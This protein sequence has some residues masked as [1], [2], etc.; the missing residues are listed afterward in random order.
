MTSKVEIISEALNLLGL[1]PISSTA[2]FPGNNPAW[3]AANKWYDRLLSS[4]LGDG[5][6]WR[7]AMVTRQLSVLTQTP[8]TDEWTYILQIPTDP[9]KILSYRVYDGI[10]DIKDYAI[11]EDKIYANQNVLYM[12]YTFEPTADKFPK[13]FTLLLIYELAAHLSMPITQDKSLLQLWSSAARA[14]TLKARA[15]DSKQA[16]SEPL[17]YGDL[18]YAHFT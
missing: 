6:P 11:Y 7:F 3:N 15:I 9:N 1:P 10:T 16:P 2:D 4:I 14:Q 17:P 8:T 13:H 12:D 18:F 5:Q